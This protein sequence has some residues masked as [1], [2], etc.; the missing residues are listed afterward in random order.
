MDYERRVGEETTIQSTIIRGMSIS[1]GC[2]YLE[3]DKR[4]Q[5]QLFIDS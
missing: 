4:L 2:N 5:S 3:Y 1:M